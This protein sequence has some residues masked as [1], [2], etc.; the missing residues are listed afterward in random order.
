MAPPRDAVRRRRVRAATVALALVVSATVAVLLVVDPTPRGWS[1]GAAVVALALVNA[2]LAVH[3]VASERAERRAQDELLAARTDAAAAAALRDALTVVHA[4]ARSFSGDLDLVTVTD[5]IVTATADALR[6]DHVELALHVRGEVAVVARVPA[7]RAPGIDPGG[8]PSGPADARVDVAPIGS[9][10]PADAVERAVLADGGTRAL[11]RGAGWGDGAS[12]LLAPV[13][14]PDRVV[15]L[16]RIGRDATSPPFVPADRVAAGLIGE[17]AA[18]A[19]RSATR[20]D[21]IVQR[22]D[23][24]TAAFGEFADDLDRA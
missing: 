3:V 13:A 17:H 18:L 20:H 4:A 11:G 14:L 6:A 21:R 10:R 15:G 19:V 22:A 23:G 5:R 7:G 8:D 9:R 1:R 16:L 2:A 12:L 24:L